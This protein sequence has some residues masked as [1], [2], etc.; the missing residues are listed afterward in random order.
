MNTINYLILNHLIIKSINEWIKCRISMPTAHVPWLIDE[1]LF[2]IDKVTDKITNYGR[3][4]RFSVH[5][6]V[7]DSLG[8]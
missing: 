2:M 8:R 7:P 6:E 1:G 5:D 4:V 3:N